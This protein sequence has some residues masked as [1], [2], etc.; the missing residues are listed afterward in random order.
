MKMEYVVTML[1]E[2]QCIL[3]Y[4]DCEADNLVEL[5]EGLVENAHV[6]LI[7]G[8]REMIFNLRENDPRL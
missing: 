1:D 4:L 5:M 6:A 8:T 2:E 7:P 3:G